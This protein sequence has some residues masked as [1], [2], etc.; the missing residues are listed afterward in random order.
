MTSSEVSYPALA[1]MTFSASV[2]T[3][4]ITLIGFLAAKG[5]FLS[6]TTQTSL[7]TLN[8]NLFTPFLIFVE[9]GSQLSFKNLADVAVIPV[10]YAFSLAVSIFTVKMVTVSCGLTLR[11][12]GFVTAMSVFGNTTSLPMPILLALAKSLP[13]LS[14]DTAA[15]GR[16]LLFIIVFQQ[17]A[18]ILRWSW[19]YNSLL[20]K[21]EVVVNNDNE[22]TLAFKDD[23]EV[24]VGSYGS[25][26]DIEAQS[27]LLV[28]AS[29]RSSTS[30]LTELTPLIKNT[31]TSLSTPLPKRCISWFF[32]VMNPPLYAIMAALIV[33]LIPVLKKV[34]FT[35]QD[36]FVAQH[37]TAALRQL[38][39]S[40]VP[41]LLLN[42]GASLVP[43]PEHQVL[44]DTK[45]SGTVVLA[46]LVSR[47]IIPPIIVLPIFSV[48]CVTLK[49]VMPVLGDPAFILV[50]FILTITPTSV[51]VAQICQI[52]G[53]FE[54]E[55]SKVLFWS[56]V[57]MILPIMVITVVIACNLIQWLF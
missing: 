41:L 16:I 2:T 56:Y 42:L 37:V 34:I 39:T 36:S 47:M 8:V 21:P 23:V 19:G 20:A 25:I 24:K 48:F 13:L 5:G 3:I 49:S 43:T 26:V 31:P 33:A 18:L 27:P 7:N 11:E 54:R 30:T 15:P 1:W 45:R 32:S 46:S 29:N 14:E 44:Q 28:S 52:N 53:V 12:R 22:E 55:M 9:L 6:K 35:D 17:L 40:A 57:V 10:F 50:C 38:S 51:Q 4:V